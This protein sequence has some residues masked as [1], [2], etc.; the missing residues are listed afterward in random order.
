MHA[1]IA[2]L[3][4]FVTLTAPAAVQAQ[5]RGL[6][7][8]NPDE[9]AVGLGNGSA[10]TSVWVRNTTGGEVTPRYAALVEDDEGAGVRLKVYAVDDEDARLDPQPVLKAGA[11]NRYRL[12]LEGSPKRLPVDSSGELVVSGVGENGEVVGSSSSI[13]L[14]ASKK[15]VPSAGV[16]GTLLW[17]LLP[18]A[19]LVLGVGSGF[20]FW[21]KQRP[22]TPLPS[23]VD[24]KE[25]FASAITGAGAVLGTILAAS[26]LPEET[27]PLSK[28]AFAALNLVFGIGIVVAGLV[29]TALQA[30]TWAP[31][32]D[33]ANKEQRATQGNLFGFLAASVITVWAVLGELW[34]TLLL[35]EELGSS[36]GFSEAA[37]WTLRILVGLALAMVVVHV[38]KRLLIVV[39]STRTKPAVDDEA[40]TARRERH[41]RA[42]A[43]GAAPA[44]IEPQTSISLL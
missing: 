7:I 1:R 5:A 18:A 33:N 32:K 41:G 35:L 27:A 36:Q 37:V 9:L 28:E 12:K 24:F 10:I 44:A 25:G 16:T 19:L 15:V 13:A 2:V 6:E 42:V 43:A 26:V 11:V 39:D 30:L 23:G 8:V 40:T 14:S 34:V 21:K 22:G 4:V 3:V 38:V 20:M 17:P 31:V 29:Y